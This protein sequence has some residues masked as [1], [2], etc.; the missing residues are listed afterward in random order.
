MLDVDFVLGLTQ[1]TAKEIL[2]G[3]ETYLKVE[4]LDP[5]IRKIV[6]DACANLKRDQEK[7]LKPKP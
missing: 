7:L 1:R 2:A 6:L 4:K 5:Q 3:L